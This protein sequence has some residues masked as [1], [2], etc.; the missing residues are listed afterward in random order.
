MNRAG[1]L[2]ESYML[3]QDADGVALEKWMAEN[4]LV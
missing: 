3:A 4:G 2:F 1:S